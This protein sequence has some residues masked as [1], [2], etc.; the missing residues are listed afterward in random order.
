MCE[1][2]LFLLWKDYLLVLSDVHDSLCIACK[3]KIKLRK[4]FFLFLIKSSLE[5]KT[6]LEIRGE[7]MICLFAF[8]L[9]IYFR[10]KSLF[11]LH[12]NFAFSSVCGDRMVCVMASPSVRMSRTLTAAE[13]CLAHK[14]FFLN[15]VRIAFWIFRSRIHP[16]LPLGEAVS[17]Y[18]AAQNSYQKLLPHHHIKKEEKTKFLK[19]KRQ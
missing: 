11:F 9:F 15:P 4:Q 5:T 17:I 12:S 8:F 1:S 18:K 13:V 6:L 3:M 10:K 7:K 2:F 16:D 19:N 14:A